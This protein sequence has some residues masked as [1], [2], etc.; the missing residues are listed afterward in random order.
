MAD[1]PVLLRRPPRGRPGD[2]APVRRALAGHLRR[3]GGGGAARGGLATARGALPITAAARA[4]AALRGLLPRGGRTSRDGLRLNLRARS[5]SSS[6]GL[7]QIAEHHDAR[8][9]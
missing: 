4:R 7:A 3:L 2:A 8:A 1:R 5:M 9:A 6:D